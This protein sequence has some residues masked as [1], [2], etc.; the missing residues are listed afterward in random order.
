MLGG[1]VSCHVVGVL[2]CLR[3]RHLQMMAMVVATPIIMPSVCHVLQLACVVV[4]ASFLVSFSLLFESVEESL[5]FLDV[6]FFELL[7]V[8]SVTAVCPLTFAPGLTSSVCVSF[9]FDHVAVDLNRSVSSTDVVSL[10]VRSIIAGGIATSTGTSLCVILVVSW[11]SVIV[12]SF[13]CSIFDVSMMLDAVSVITFRLVTHPARKRQTMQI[14]IRARM[15]VFLSLVMAVP[16]C[17]R[18]R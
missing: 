18:V 13:S 6:V 2:A 4:L 14:M 3:F 15:L 17:I 10:V 7:L 5:V 9:P 8:V 1:E 12:V 16:P 11:V